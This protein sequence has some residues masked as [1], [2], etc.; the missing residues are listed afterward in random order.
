MRNSV[1]LYL[2]H[3]MTEEA[4]KESL[5]SSLCSYT[6]CDEDEAKSYLE[7]FDWSVEEA[8]M[9]IYQD[10]KRKKSS[11]SERSV[12]KHNLS[13]LNSDT[14]TQNTQIHKNRKSCAQKILKRQTRSCFGAISCR[15]RKKTWTSLSERIKRF[16]SP[17]NRENICSPC[18]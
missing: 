9:A 1:K 11:T 6:N 5:V 2:R 12:R 17:L 15:K 3:R 18:G 4:E 14:H 16:E 10:R 13:S 7:K 8:S